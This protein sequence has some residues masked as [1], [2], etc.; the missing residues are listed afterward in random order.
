MYGFELYNMKYGILYKPNM[1]KLI[2]DI[3]NRNETT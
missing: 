1:Q 3:W 2:A